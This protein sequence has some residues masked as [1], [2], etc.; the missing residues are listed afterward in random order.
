M[1]HAS[2]RHR[3]DR[4]NGRTE[5]R[6]ARRAR[7]SWRSDAPAILF[8]TVLLFGGGAGTRYP[9]IELVAQLLALGLIVH[10]ARAE[11]MV[12]GSATLRRFLLVF[13][14][15]MLVLAL[16]TVP[17]PAAWWQSLPGRDAAVRIYTL[18]G[19]AEHW[20][21]FSL[22]PDATFAALFAFLVPLAA[23]LTVASLPPRRRVIVLRSIVAA[24]MVG[25]VLAML[26]VAAGTGSAPILYETAHRGFGVG[27]FVN[28]NHQAVFLLVAIVF[29]A[30]PGVM[31]TGAARRLALLGAIGFLSLGVLATSSRTALLLLPIALIV[32]FALV[33]DVRRSGKPVLGA[34]ML[35]LVG[36]V[37]LSRSDLVQRVLA[38]FATVAEEL[39]Y[40]YWENT[41]Y[42]VRETFPFGTGL[43]SFVPVYRSIEPLGQVSPLSVNH[44]HNDFLELILEGGL[45]AALLILVGLIVLVVALVSGWRAAGDRQDRATLVAGG[46]ATA[47]ILLFSL[48]D[49][50]L[51]MAAIAGLFGTS[52]GLIA[53]IGPSQSPGVPL[54]RSRWRGRVVAAV[55]VVAG[56]AVSGDAVGRFLMQSGQPAAATTIAPWSA[57]AWSALADAEQLAGR[58]AGARLAAARALAI[59]PIDAAAVRAHGYADLALNDPK[60]GSALMQA[61][62][63]L[64]WRDTLMQLWLG[65]GALQVG[66]LGVAAERIDALLRRGQMVDAL[67]R[68]MQRTYG[69]PG[70][71]DAIVARLAE[72]PQWR[73]GLLNAIADDAARS[74]P[75]TLDF[76]AKLRAA[77]VAATPQETILI[78]WRLADLGDFAGARRVWLASGG[79]GLL[80]DGGF[81][82]LSI[83]L[84]NGV[85]PYGWSAPNL[86][87]VRVIPADRGADGRGHA[88][89]I[90]SDG[91]SSGTALA[92]AIV[93]PP[94]RWRV[95]AVARGSD[96]PA[97]L[98]LACSDGAASVLPQAIVLDGQGSGWR[99]VGGIFTIGA[100]CPVQILRV[101]LRE[102]GGQ[103]GVFWIDEIRITPATG[104]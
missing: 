87:G 49:Y 66:S 44:A 46:T 30:V 89:Q 36:G 78:R 60:R 17:L 70:G 28:R 103:N 73:Q 37:L 26:Q 71:P 99:P 58:P 29:A 48:V 47:L 76:L 69:A 27:F 81:E 33:G 96:V 91:L 100:E 35:Y 50:P 22:A 25:T 61:G 68:Q 79:R 6:T 14:A 4:H 16:Q 94:G 5:G 56:V 59:V 63:A 64:G 72:R 84:Q 34:A 31:G 104:K 85:I 54:V 8:L 83:P 12:V 41:L 74:V 20:H 77:G 18:L 52:L 53:A 24:A 39:R 80:A 51:R 19:W 15:A 43:G 75:R 86:P 65:E 7:L 40:Q 10:A 101:M 9:L 1:S 13:A 98:S 82:A 88:V 95:D 57:S 23:M 11:T 90:V 3:S 67:M 45:P 32:A 93:L 102:R 97:T 55:A 62:A 42:A 21:A 38:R 2:V 92:Q